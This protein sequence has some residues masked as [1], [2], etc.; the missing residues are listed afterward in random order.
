M[1]PQG[2]MLGVSSRV[3]SRD[4]EDLFSRYGRVVVYRGD[5]FFACCYVR[6]SFVAPVMLSPTLACPFISLC[7]LRYGTSVLLGRG[8]LF[9]EPRN[10]VRV[11]DVELKYLPRLYPLGL[12]STFEPWLGCF[13][14]LVPVVREVLVNILEGV[15]G[16]FLVHRV[17]VA[18]GAAAVVIA[19]AA[20]TVAS[21]SCTK[22]RQSLEES[23]RQQESK[24]KPPSSKG[25]KPKPLSH[26]SRSPQPRPRMSAVK[27]S[28]KGPTAGAQER[29]SR[30]PCPCSPGRERSP[31][32][33]YQ[34]PEAN[35]ATEPQED[36]ATSLRQRISKAAESPRE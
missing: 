28:E 4:L 20:V 26:G 11:P 34:S 6:S 22:E 19:A 8:D 27:L 29:E 5:S 32:E 33:R 17:L 16:V 35:V 25:K 21:F 23:P 24:E 2:C 31:V 10:P 15:G 18:E 14:P 30:S 3:R 9:R 36:A 1:E 7:G 12:P 13:Q